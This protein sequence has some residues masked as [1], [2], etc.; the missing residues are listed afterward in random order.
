MANSETHG[1]QYR[2]GFQSSDAPSIANFFARSADLRYEP[3]VFVPATDGE[4]HT[5]AVALSKSSH[6][7]ITGTFTGYISASFSGNQ[8][9]NTFN[10]SVG[11][12]SRFFIVRNISEP[13][14]KGNFVEVSLEAESYK[15][16]TS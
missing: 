7:K 4:G 13:R 3:E 12:T 6:R 8:I 9:G 10:F 11:G 14:Q 16:V 2:F 1:S 15:L 5:E